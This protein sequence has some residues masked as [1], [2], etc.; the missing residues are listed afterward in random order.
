MNVIFRKIRRLK[1]SSNK[2]G[3]IKQHLRYFTNKYLNQKI[4]YSNY[5]NHETPARIR[6]ETTNICNLKCITCPQNLHSYNRKKEIMPMDVFEK[7][8]NEIKYFNP[9][10]VVSLYH[11]GE[12]LSNPNIFECIRIVKDA[13]MYCN[14]NSNATLLTKSMSNKL[15]DSGLDLIEFSFDDV[16]PIEYEKMRVNAKYDQTLNNILSFLHIKKAGKYKKPLVVITGIKMKYSGLV[17]NI[18]RLGAS[19]SFM[20]IFSGFD[21]SFSHY[22]A[23]AWGKSKKNKYSPCPIVHKDFNI[24][25]NGF[26]VP[27]CYDLNGDVIMGNIH[28]S[29]IKDIWNN[30]DYQEL[31]KLLNNKKHYEIEGLCRGCPL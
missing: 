10:P 4:D 31:R 24:L 28:E 17:D 13:G 15:L 1:N 16:E 6:I 18:E 11:R 26:V 5:I 22:Y 20:N 25:S 29:T 23:H 8:V 30:E 21:V 14:F 12:P 2:A 7:I 27:C 19:K 3:L 9:K